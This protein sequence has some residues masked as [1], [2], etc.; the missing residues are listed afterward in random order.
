[1]TENKASATATVM[2]FHRAIEMLYPEEDRVCSDPF[3]VSFLPPEWAALL[4]DIDQLK[5]VMEPKAKEFPGINGAVV[6][7]VRFIDDIL[8]E[9]LK[10]GAKQVVIIGAGYDS[11]AFRFEGYMDSVT[12]FELDHPITQ[13]DK[14]HKLDKNLKEK[15][16]H[17]SYISLDLA[18]EKLLE[19]LTENGY[20]PCEKSI[21]IMEGLVPYIYLNVFEDILRLISA[22]GAVKNSVVF[23]YLPPSVVDG[24]SDLT[25]GKNMYKEVKI[26]GEDFKLGFEPQELER[27]FQKYDFQV[28]ENINAPDL[29][30]TYFHG[31][32][33]QRPISSVFWLAHGVVATS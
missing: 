7:R 28:L 31:S 22:K 13:Q 17:I 1:M 23:D 18:Q 21:F 3:A 32:S 10:Q 25:E 24:T 33:S 8:L 27:L 2:A 14:L 20:D 6:C 19:R 9:A 15:T 30:E 11:R 4:K 12:V 16:S 26:S 5:A 29:R